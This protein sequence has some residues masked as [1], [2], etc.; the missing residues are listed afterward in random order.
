M[1]SDL[2]DRTGTLSGQRLE[3]AQARLL[4]YLGR[5]G[6]GTAPDDEPPF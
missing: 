1:K 2:E 3:E 6:A 5:I 4:E